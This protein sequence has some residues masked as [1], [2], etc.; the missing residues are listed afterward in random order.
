MTPRTREFV[1][2]LTV[3]LATLAGILALALPLP[4]GHTGLF[5]WLT[6]LCAALVPIEF[7]VGNGHTRPVQLALVPMLVLLPP[8]LV[9][10][11]VL[12]AA[13][14]TAIA[15]TLRGRRPARDLVLAVADSAY[16]I[17]PALVVAAVPGAGGVAL[18]IVA[19][20]ASD[21]ALTAARLR[22]GVGIDV[23]G[24]LGVF[25]WMYLVDACL[26][27]VGYLAAVAGRHHPG[28]PALVLPLAGLLVVFA[29]ERRGRIENAV[30]LQDE[31]QKGRERLQAIVGNSS[32][33]IVIVTPGGV[34]HT[35][36]GSATPLFGA[37]WERVEG[38]SVFAHTHPQD[39]ALVAG[40]LETV[41]A[42]PA[43]EPQES[44]WRMRFPDG[45]HRHVA[46][47]AANQ[48]AD[49]RIRGLV[50]TLRD[51]EARK[52]FEEQLRHQAFHDGLTGLANRALFH[53]RVEHALSRGTRAGGEVAVLFID[54]DGFKAV[55]DVHGH[56]EGD[57]L[58][59]EVARRLDLT[60]RSA[61]TAARLGGDEFAVLLE[62][63][64]G[65]TTAAARILD[66]LAQPIELP[67][68]AVTVSASIGLAV[69]RAG[70]GGVEGLLR[71]ADLAMYEAKRRG[72][73]R[74]ELF[75][76]RLE[77]AGDESRWAG[78]D[79]EQ[80]AEI[81]S[82]LEDPDAIA[83][84]FQPIMD[85]RTGRVAG[86][87][88]LARFQREPRRTP[89]RWF[90]Q[91]HRCGLGY[92]L[93][94]KAVA[95]A[96]ATPDRP[97]GTYLSV[98][99][100]PSSLLSPE[101][102]RVLP[103]RLDG[104]VIEIT[105]NELVADDAELQQA[106]AGLRARGARLAVDDIGAGYAGLTHVM[107]LQ[108][109]MLKLD[110]ALTTGVDADPARA[111]LVRSFVRYAAE[112]G[113]TVCAEGVETL[114]ELI[115]LADLD[116]GF[117]QGYG[118]ARPGAP[119]AGVAGEAAAACLHAFAAVLTGADDRLDAFAGHVTDARSA[120]ELSAVLQPLAAGLG[121]GVLRVAAA[122]GRGAVQLLADDPAADPA[123]AAA[124]RAEGF[125]SCLTLPIPYGE[126]VVGQLELL[127]HEPHPWT[128]EQILRARRVC[129][130]LGA[131]LRDLPV[132]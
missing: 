54:L 85:L 48:L 39:A 2:E 71:Q 24:D 15:R 34:M 51:V 44:E 87:E 9:P 99:L 1:T 103:E 43:G 94:A 55:N 86:Y 126:R 7:E 42:K 131:V 30:A 109:D 74:V 26:A 97:P 72:K 8:G 88:A 95:A 75:E 58:L 53:D 6:L 35:L 70:D 46:A 52:A 25:L 93:E 110:R 31:A 62:G 129:N 115:R 130:Q 101:V 57:R 28:L 59:Q 23:R 11:G 132:A 80:R 18:A 41:A 10:L 14:P 76:P 125:A 22:V 17:A 77:S 29:R 83:M 121:A 120:E 47:V 20:M 119:W 96:L 16:A 116:V 45:S 67:G 56:A 84:A 64:A 108:P 117:G 50:L 37:D 19:L 118:I 61:D 90:A 13:L 114:G 60:L 3:G 89:D 79:D 66:V 122:D 102:L 32:D 107:R 111:A 49:E 68:G 82:V 100:S 38:D 106:F 21:F 36:T 127:A 81:L 33:C 63:G 40:F 69:A 5:V 98:N 113:A 92:A 73:G 112:I 104:F 12:L 65:A 123:A 105:E 128:R 124:L 91:A 27:P 78:H 4:H